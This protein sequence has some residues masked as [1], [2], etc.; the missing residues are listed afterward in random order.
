MRFVKQ[1]GSSLS[2]F[3]LL[4]DGF[5]F[6]NALCVGLHL[7][8]ASLS[9]QATDSMQRCAL[10]CRS[11]ADCLP[12]LTPL[13]G[14]LSLSPTKQFCCFLSPPVMV[15]PFSQRQCEEMESLGYNGEQPAE[16]SSYKHYKTVVLPSHS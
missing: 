5:Y 2:T 12:Y 7:L 13:V 8:Y 14:T 10:V 6:A 4:F 15:G 1:Q 11:A 3:T 9:V 16:A